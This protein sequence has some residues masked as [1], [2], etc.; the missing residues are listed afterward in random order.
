MKFTE[1]H[2]WLRTEGAVVVVGITEHATPQLGD[3]V[4][5][6]VPEVGKVIEQKQTTTAFCF[7]YE[8]LNLKLNINLEREAIEFY[9][10]ET[11]NPDSHIEP[12]PVVKKPD[13]L[14]F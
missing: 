5:V 12:G 14:P 13:D 9:D 3:I 6:E 10:N 11:T 2:E 7:D 1:E 4:F 8:M